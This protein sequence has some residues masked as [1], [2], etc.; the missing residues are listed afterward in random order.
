MV[1]ILGLLICVG[2]IIVVIKYLCSLH[3]AMRLVPREKRIF[4]NAFI[5]LTII[6]YL[7][8]IFKWLMLAFGIPQGLK[9]SMIDNMVAVSDA[10]LLEKLGL[11][12]VILDTLS[13]GVAAAGIIEKNTHLAVLFGLIMS[14]PSFALWIVY[15]IQ[16][17]RF[18]KTYLEKSL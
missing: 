6:P 8:L 3:R 14:L 5:W 10:S 12:I 16:V 18:R 2:L 1:A 4:P 7:G 11:I 9:N 13:L 15:W 17:V